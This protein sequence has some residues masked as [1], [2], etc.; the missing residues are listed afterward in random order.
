MLKQQLA[1]YSVRT[2]AETFVQLFIR[3][4][5][6]RLHHYLSQLPSKKAVTL[7]YEDEWGIKNNYEYITRALTHLSKLWFQLYCLI[8]MAQTE[9]DE[10][11]THVFRQAAA[12]VRPFLKEHLLAGLWH[13]GCRQPPPE[14]ANSITPM[15]EEDLLVLAS[16]I[17][18]FRLPVVV[19]TQQ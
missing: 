18:Q 11:A 2:P 5:K 17:C 6:D 3:L 4:P 14:A 12:Y 19:Q 8:D 10:H 15:D 13:Y 7:W 1:L 16:N 9:S